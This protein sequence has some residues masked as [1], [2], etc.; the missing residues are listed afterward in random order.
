MA[1]GTEALYQQLSILLVLAT[2]SHF[3]I[4]R[5]HR[6]TILGDTFNLYPF[7]PTLVASFAALGAIFLLFLI[8]LESDFRAIYKTK[9]VLVATGGVVLPLAFG[10]VTALFL[11]PQA[12]LGA[13]GNQ[14]TM[15]VFMGAT[16][17]ATSTAIA[18]SVLLDLGL[19][20]EPVAQTI[21]GAAV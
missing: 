4:K 16:L 9:N 18:A 12:G 20:R 19:M 5:F 21:M 15:A 10:F 6:P 11:V 1:V 13:N 3:T 8:G 17:T 7:D 2:L 14:F